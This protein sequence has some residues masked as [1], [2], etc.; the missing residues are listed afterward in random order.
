M[1]DED[2]YGQRRNTDFEYAGGSKMTADKAA[3][4]AK[5]ET[6]FGQGL[7]LKDDSPAGQQAELEQKLVGH[8][9]AGNLVQ[10][11]DAQKLAQTLIQETQTDEMKGLNSQGQESMVSLIV[12]QTL[13]N[14]NQPSKQMPPKLPEGIKNIMED[15]SKGQL[16]HSLDSNRPEPKQPKQTVQAKNKGPGPGGR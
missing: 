6:R 13:Q 10:E 16:L 14:F 3:T 7:T 9:T 8:L 5:L 15:M 11:N 12:S 2:G 4:I 1:S